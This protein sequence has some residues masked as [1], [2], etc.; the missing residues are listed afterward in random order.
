MSFVENPDDTP[1]QST[2]K[3]VSYLIQTIENHSEN[4]SLDRILGDLQKIS[5]K[6]QK[7]E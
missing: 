4:A 5:E 7:V 3:H 2:K 1:L 6:L